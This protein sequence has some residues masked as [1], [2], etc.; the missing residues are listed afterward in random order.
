MLKTANIDIFNNKKCH[1]PSNYRP[2]SLVD[3]AVK[4]FERIML[5]QKIPFTTEKFMNNYQSGYQNDVLLNPI[6]EF[7]AN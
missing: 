4:L 2:I 1:Q 6:I 7:F 5:K 3:C